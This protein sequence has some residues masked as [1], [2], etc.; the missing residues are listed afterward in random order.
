[1]TN[2]TSGTVTSCKYVGAIVSDEDSK[3]EVLS[4]QRFRSLFISSIHVNLKLKTQQGVN[5]SASYLDYYLCI[6]NGKFVTVVDVR[7]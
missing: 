6:D 4:T 1:M 5:T 7:T 3:P 2:S